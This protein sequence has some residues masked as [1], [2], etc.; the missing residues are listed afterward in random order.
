[1]L[2]SKVGWIGG[3]CPAL[4]RETDGVSAGM[5]GNWTGGLLR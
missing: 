1:M 2:L 5:G 4:E 3:L